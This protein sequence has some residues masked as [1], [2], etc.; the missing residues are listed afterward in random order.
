[1]SKNNQDKSSNSSGELGKIDTGKQINISNPN[2]SVIET[3]LPDF[4]FTPP[5]PPP[6]SKPD[7]GSGDDISE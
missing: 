1:M 5:P 2:R 4:K 7:E 6:P 3:S